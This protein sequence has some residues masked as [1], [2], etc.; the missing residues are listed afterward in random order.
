MENLNITVIKQTL[1]IAH[2]ETLKQVQNNR[3]ILGEE[4]VEVLL[5]RAK[6]YIAAEEY[7]D[8]L[9]NSTPVNN[10]VCIEGDNTLEYGKKII[11]F[12]ESLGG[13]NKYNWT[14]KSD[15]GYYFIRP[16][17][18]IYLHDGI[19]EGYTEISLK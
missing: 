18:K 1:N 19:P 14:G 6:Q 7:L 12:L 13:F 8:S 17:G 15:S 11:E 16:N 3:L 9:A 2:A 4:G 5:A 10:K